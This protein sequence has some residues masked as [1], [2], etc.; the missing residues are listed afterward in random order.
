LS[1]GVPSVAA[2]DPD[3]AAAQGRSAGPPSGLSVIVITLDEEDNLRRCLASVADLAEEIVVVDSGSR[4]RTVEIAAEFG[5]TIHRQEFLGYERQKQCALDLASGDWVLSLDA[6][7]WLD[8]IAR[9]EVA[10]V[11]HGSWSGIAGYALRLR[12]FYLGRFLRFGG[13]AA[14]WKLRLVRRELARF[15]GGDVHER[16][17]V[18]GPTRRLRGRLC[19]LPYRDLSRQ[20]EKIDRYTDILARR[21]RVS[22]RR[23][24][25]GMTVEPALVVVH[26]LLIQRGLLDGTRG[27]VAAAMEAWY[28]FL[29]YAKQWD[30]RSSASGRQPE[31]DARDGAPP[32]P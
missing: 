3:S 29:R 18:D 15:V 4:D 26:R 9:E 8:A 10:Q 24:L 25:F 22:S 16:M 27:I 1:G 17:V 11:L 13:A 19:H 5:A 14:E 23:A 21:D 20:L 31:V 28:F 2:P 32:E 7:E 6:D 30:R 12:V